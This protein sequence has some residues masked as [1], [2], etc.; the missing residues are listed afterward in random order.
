MLVQ[1]CISGYK[2]MRVC[3]GVFLSVCVYKY[4]Y[5]HMSCVRP[6]LCCMIVCLWRYAF[7][8]VSGLFLGLFV[9]HWAVISI[10]YLEG[11]VAYQISS[12]PVAHPLPNT[13]SCE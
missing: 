1:V 9:R 4:K 8:D 2:W 5:V 12:L 13:H 7:F 6:W 11:I 10:M 3:V